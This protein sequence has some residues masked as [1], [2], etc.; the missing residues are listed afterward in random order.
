MNTVTP[1]ATGCSPSAT[2][3][4]RNS[5]VVISSKED[6]SVTVGS[7]S[8][9]VQTIPRSNVSSKKKMSEPPPPPPKQ[10][11]A[12]VEEFV[13]EFS[14]PRDQPRAFL[15]GGLR[16]VVPSAHGLADDELWTQLDRA[17]QPSSSASLA[18]AAASGAALGNAASVVQPAVQ[19]GMPNQP[20]DYSGS[21]TMT[22]HGSTDQ[23]LTRR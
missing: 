20:E 1:A 17:L 6:D 5:V 15:L 7:V 4:S 9:S 8:S 23:R 21:S 13:R 12:S 3:P 2:A 19:N 14:I 22:S 16:A 10:S 18:A 11:F